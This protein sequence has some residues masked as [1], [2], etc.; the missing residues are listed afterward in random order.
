MPKFVLVEIKTP[1]DESQIEFLILK[2]RLEQRTT[3]P[4]GENA[5]VNDD[6]YFHKV[7]AKA[8]KATKSEV[9]ASFDLDAKTFTVQIR[10]YLITEGD[11]SF[12]RQA[13]WIT[14]K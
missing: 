1:A 4:F 9:G 6:F 10:K 5:S 2:L 13:K 14:F 11:S 3:S 12:E 8:F 7:V